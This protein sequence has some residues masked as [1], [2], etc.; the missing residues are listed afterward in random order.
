MTR[1]PSLRELFEQLAG[2]SE[3]PHATLEAAGYGD[4]EPHLV[5][6]AIVNYAHGAPVEVAEHLS[7]FVVSHSGVPQGD[8]GDHGSP[9]TSDGLSMLSSAPAP[10]DLQ[11]YHSEPDHPGAD[12]DA[13]HDGLGIDDLDADHTAALTVHA[14][15]DAG[16]TDDAAG[17]DGQ[18]GSGD[19]S[20][21]TGEPGTSAAGLAAADTGHDAPAADVGHD[22]LAGHDPGWL[23][24][25]GTGDQAAFDLPADDDWTHAQHDHV[26]DHSVGADEA[27]DGH[28]ASGAMD[29]GAGA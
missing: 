14:T 28:D 24:V 8:E 11:P 21:G 18:P 22:D 2:G 1:V 23:D 5:D 16:H 15:D 29:A 27:H 13:H 17:H 25:V 9:D 3:D 6:E 20:F 26:D 4:L 10:A 19:L 7:P 12:H